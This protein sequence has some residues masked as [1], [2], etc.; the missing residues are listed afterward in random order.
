[1]I[2][3]FKKKYNSLITPL[4]SIF[5]S[6]FLVI[7]PIL[8]SVAGK[9]APIAMMIVCFVAYLVGYVIR[10]NIKNVEPKMESNTGSKLTSTLEKISDVVLIPAYVI[11]ITLY[12]KI[13][14]SF[15]LEPFNMDTHLF[16]NSVVTVILLGILIISIIKGLETLNFLEKYA[17]LLTLVLIAALFIFYFKFDVEQAKVGFTW[18]NPEDSLLHKIR[19]IAG[20]LIVVQGFETTRYLSFEFDEKTRIE[21]CRKSQIFSSIIYIVFVTLAIPIMYKIDLTGSIGTNKLIDL[22]RIAAPMLVVPLIIAAVFSQFSAAVADCFG[23]SGNMSEITK[24]KLSVKKSSCIIIV[25]AL[26]LTWIINSGRVVSLASQAFAL[27][28]LIQS[29]SALSVATKIRDKILFSILI[30]ILFFITFFSLQ[31]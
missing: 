11:S 9:Y 28:Y 16:E 7:A 19:I 31:A 6:G 14:A 20:T 24:N 3:I 4:A 29:A 2:H 23:A 17:L 8:A 26:I 22:T 5:G 18:T 27:Y 30:V 10:F 25:G 21:A 1:M 13:L 15:L 12:L